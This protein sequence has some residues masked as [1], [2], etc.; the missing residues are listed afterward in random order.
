MPD[1]FYVLAFWPLV[2]LVL[3]AFI[4]AYVMAGKAQRQHKRADRAERTAARVTAE[5]AIT[6]EHLETVLRQ[7][8]VG[9]P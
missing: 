3:L 5:L 7:R 1:T 4:A 2:V 9:T 6:T 8:E